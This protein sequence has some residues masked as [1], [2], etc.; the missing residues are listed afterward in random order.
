MQFQGADSAAIHPTQLAVSASLLTHGTPLEEVVE[1]LLAAT[2]AAAGLAGARWDWQREERDILNM[3][4]TWLAKHPEVVESAGAKTTETTE[5]TE[6][7]TETTE[8]TETTTETTEATETASAA[9]IM[10]TTETTE[11]AEAAEAAEIAATAESAAVNP[12]GQTGEHSDEADD[13]KAEQAEA[14][15][16]AGKPIANKPA[17]N[18]KHKRKVGRATLVMMI[19]D[20]VIKRVRQDGGDLLLTAGELHVYRD[21]IW[22]VADTAVEQYLHVL[23][24]EGTETLG[25]GGDTKLL[26]A[27]WR[28]LLEHPGLYCAHV[29]W[30]ATGKIAVTNGVLDLRTREFTT[31]RPQHFLRHKLAVAYEP[32]AQAPQFNAFLTRLFADRDTE[33]AMA[34]ISLLQEFAGAALCVRLLHREQRRAL[35]LVGPSRT[36]K[37]ELARLYARL[38]GLPIASPSV[39]QI[40]ERFGL[41]CF[42]D[43][44]AWVR[45][46]AVNEGDRL[47][48]QRFKT[49]VTGEAIDIERK[50]RAAVRVELAIPVVLTANSL[51]ASRDASDAV[52]NRSLVVDLTQVFDD[53]A[54]INV[55][56][57]LG[58]PPGTKW[59]ADFLF[60]REGPGVLNWALTGL[61]EL[62]KR[63]TFDI[64]ETVGAAIQ[65]FKD[66][67][68]PVAEFSRTMLEQSADTKIDRADMLC[69]FHGWFREEAGDTAKLPGARWLVPKL[70]TA[71]PWA[72]PRKM[73]GKRYFCGVKLTDEALKYWF[74]QASA[75]QQSGRGSK[76]ASSLAKEVNQDWT[77]K[78]L[79]ETA[80][81]P[82]F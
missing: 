8:T 2:R 37:S 75:A 22:S 56:R 69:A 72:V 17:D 28:R 19:C 41:A 44:T 81:Y 64:P 62:L 16:T 9:E 30:D 74:E 49:I 34:L 27:A 24:Q 68:N 32:A 1:M 21:G 3:C 33:T 47:D 11:T 51:P 57:R 78:E 12:D 50:N 54:A 71:C 43:A 29:E 4:K 46:D 67:S 53:Q 77:Q 42:F 25:Y 40:S 35:F 73:K 82:P 61:D 65:R 10:E 23:L 14:P 66:E 13:T 79:D 59:L 76:G 55:R 26:T 45:D 70:R 18:R 48:P 63:G 52:F 80:D 7:T 36:G 38:I 39:G 31:W 5:T 58:V 20:G 15:P 6:T 60:D